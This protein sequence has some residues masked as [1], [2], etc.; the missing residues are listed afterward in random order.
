MR[1]SSPLGPVSFRSV[2][3]NPQKLRMRDSV[4]WHK[5]VWD[6]AVFANFTSSYMNNIPAVAERVSDYR[7]LI[8]SRN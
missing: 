1:L 3:G 5:G 2:I 8:T 7:P 6:A 4:T